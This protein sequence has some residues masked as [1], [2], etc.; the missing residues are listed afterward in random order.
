MIPPLMSIG[1]MKVPT[2]EPAAV[3]SQ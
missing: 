1:E 2:G 3:H